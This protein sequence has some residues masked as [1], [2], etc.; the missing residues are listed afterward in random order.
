MTAD[1]GELGDQ[2]QVSFL[3]GR[4]LK[5]SYSKLRPGNVVQ[6]FNINGETLSPP[7]ITS[8]ASLPS[9]RPTPVPV[10]SGPTELSS[11]TSATVCWVLNSFKNGGREVAYSVSS[12]SSI[13]MNHMSL[14]QDGEGEGKVCVEGNLWDNF[15]SQQYTFEVSVLSTL[16][17]TTG[18]A[19]YSFL[20]LPSPSTK[21]QQSSPATETSCST[22]WESDTSSLYGIQ[23]F[24]SGKVY[25]PA[26]L[27]NENLVVI[28]RALSPCGET[29]LSRGIISTTSMAWDF[30]SGGN[31]LNA[32]DFSEDSTRFVIPKNVLSDRSN[33]PVGETVEIRVRLWTELDR[34]G[35]EYSA[36]FSFEFLAG[37]VVP[38]LSGNLEYSFENTFL[39]LD[40]SGSQTEDGVGIGNGNWEVLWKCEDV[41]S[42]EPCEYS[43]GTEII[44]PGQNSFLFQS[45]AGKEFSL[46]VG[47]MFVVHFKVEFDGRVSLGK[48][49]RV[50]NAVEGDGSSGVQLTFS[51]WSCF[52][53]FETNN[54]GYFVRINAPSGVS[55]ENFVIESLW[56][57]GMN[58]FGDLALTSASGQAGFA[59]VRCS[60]QSVCAEPVLLRI[61]S[62]TDAITQTFYALYTP[63]PVLPPRGGSCS[64]VYETFEGVN[65]DVPVSI[66]SFVVVNCRGWQYYDGDSSVLAQRIYF[67][68]VDEGEGTVINPLEYPQK[69]NAYGP[70][71]LVL[72]CGLVDV[73]VQLFGYGQTSNR[74]ST[75][76]T[77]QLSVLSWEDGQESLFED[78]KA[79]IADSPNEFLSSVFLF[80]SLKTVNQVCLNGAFDPVDLN[81][82]LEDILDSDP[83]ETVDEVLNEAPILVIV[84]QSNNSDAIIDRFQDYIDVINSQ[85]DLDSSNELGN[86]I[87]D[88]VGNLIDDDADTLNS[89]DDLLGDVEALLLCFL[90]CGADPVLIESEDVSIGAN[91]DTVENLGSSLI[92][93]G[94]GALVQLP[95]DLQALQASLGGED[96]CVF[97]GSSVVGE[98]GETPVAS[99][100]FY[101]IN[102]TSGTREEV[103]IAG[104]G[105]FLIY[106]PYSGPVPD[107]EDDECDDED[108]E[109]IS[110]VSGSTL[111]AVTDPSGCRVVDVN[112]TFITCGCS[113]LTAFSALFVPGSGGGKCGGGDWEWDIL[114]T[115]AVSLLAFCGLLIV[116]GLMVEHNLVH[117]KRQERIKDKTKGRKKT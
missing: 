18:S 112:A 99:F 95:D 76:T 77:S 110:C 40:F 36:T 12:S 96:A 79:L 17:G 69:L 114:Q 57:E 58:S 88:G 23:T 68:V 70:I 116:G 66:F 47:Y 111:G 31:G 29:E 44:L 75:F 104:D 83:P 71:Q 82:V 35:D 5:I 90:E 73:R 14:T 9:S 103:S 106:L 3:T 62:T 55:L 93:L 65:E 37:E 94:D 60:C 7:L 48:W 25:L 84:G 91:S 85:G 51:Q 100:T 97:T 43:D 8:V 50:L 61:T 109:E 16:F 63:P 72:P 22:L 4:I 67:E 74:S 28:A 98:G 81:E 15:P 41:V 108:E 107:D 13:F 20:L 80:S 49:V 38:Q 78:A 64:V 1:S 89:I 86:I 21:R 59:Q 11:H 53:T 32:D 33:F 24:P 105:E 54:F 39:E 113:H 6:F 45:D 92:D 27:R 115:V 19:S 42:Q 34:N 2:C 117:K 101:V 26:S 87:A 52:D 30:V 56:S 102:C 10:I 46:G